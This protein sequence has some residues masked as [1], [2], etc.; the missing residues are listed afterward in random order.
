MAA[1]A[2]ARRTESAYPRFLEAQRAVD[3]AVI[4]RNPLTAATKL[5]AVEKLPEVA[6]FERFDLFLGA[7]RTDRGLAV[8]ILDSPPAA[9]AD[10]RLGSALHKPKILRG[11]RPSP[12]RVDEV[13]VGFLTAER[14]GL[15]VGSEL[16][17]RLALRTLDQLLAFQQVVQ[18]SRDAWDFAAGPTVAL[19]V[20]GIEAMPGGFPPLAPGQGPPLFLTPAFHQSYSEGTLTAAGTAIILKDESTL[21]GFRDAAERIMG[22]GGATFLTKP[23]HASKIQRATH[24]QVVGLSLMAGLTGFAAL[25][26]LSQAFA[27]QVF[28]ESADYPT[29]AAIGMTRRQLWGLGVARAALLCGPAAL[30]AIAVAVL[31]SP[32]TPIGLARIA[33]PDPGFRV[34]VPVVAIGVPVLIVAILLTTS[35]PAWLAAKTTRA[36]S[37]G[38]ARTPLQPLTALGSMLMLLRPPAVV[39]AGIRMALQPRGRDRDAVPVRSTITCASAGVAALAAAVLFGTSL[40]HLVRTPELYGQRWDTRIGSRAIRDISDDVVPL[41]HGNPAISEISEGTI[42]EA[43]IGGQVVGVLAVDSLQGQPFAVA[44]EGRA[45]HSAD[46]ILLG[47]RT[48]RQVKARIGDRIDVRMGDSSRSMAIVGRGVHP[49]VGDSGRFGEG[50]AMT[51]QGLKAL[52]P[53]AARNVF[54]VRFSPRVDRDQTYGELQETFSRIGMAR[55]GPPTELAGFGRSEDLPFLLAV[56]VAVVG[57]VTMVH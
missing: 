1:A 32:A 54:L 49:D 44:I 36:T 18:G 27:R 5:D 29:L 37:S 55:G 53:G 13:S 4:D 56:L 46:E 17:L 40:Q 33:E 14:F 28:A 10:G 19:R 35:L 45:P 6:E 43:N 15:D 52:N 11:R 31:L 34:D 50:V 24:L 41:L 9:T 47:S 21:G 42:T 25:V 22:P 30:C 2:G 20:V 12:E 39:L 26:I 7:I 48:F 51:F 57:A 3:I 16:I 23:E 38:S 8:P